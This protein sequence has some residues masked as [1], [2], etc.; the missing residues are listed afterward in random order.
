MQ[1]ITARKQAEQALVQ[2]KDEAE[3]ATRAKSTFLATMSHEIRTPLNGVLGMA[4][5]MAA[6]PME[7]EQRE[8]LEVI[9]QSGETLL[10]VLNDILDLSK[11][12]AGR[13]EL[14]EAGFDIADVASAAHAAFSAVAAQKNISF[15]LKV[16]RAAAGVYLGDAT[17][18]RQLLNNLISNAL[19][20]TEAGR[21]TIR[22]GRRGSAIALAVT[23]TG[24]GIS[25]AQQT[26]L[27]E[28]FAQAD[29][30]TT[31]RFGGTGLGLAICRDL[32]E[33]MGG[34]IEAKSI[35]GQGSTFIAILPLPRAQRPIRK[36]PASGVRTQAEAHSDHTSLRL[37]AAEDNPVN[38]LVLKTLLSQLGLQV[39]VVCDGVDAVAAWESRDWDVILMDV[40]MPRMDGPSATRFIRE[41]ERIQ[42][43]RRTPIIAL[44]ANAMTHQVNEYLAAGMDD[45]VSKPV[46]VHRLLKALDAA[47][48]ASSMQAEK[49]GED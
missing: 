7:T 39:E 36:T 43:R 6:G 2:A 24:I 47:L 5:A 31:R 42:G 29:A 8:R 44:T 35:E 19:K 17:R 16:S 49:V 37:L 41:R 9:R 1:N 23:D 4:Q 28:K 21:V 25:E 13:L 30:S 38:Q 14:E 18:V 48:S 3:A 27:F 15:D 26:A 45:F 33:L 12:E 22:V 32:A 11:I 34:R 10:A 20:F 40:Q 46:D